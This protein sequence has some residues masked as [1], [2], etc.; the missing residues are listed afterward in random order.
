MLFLTIVI[1]NIIVI[2][3]ILS[4]YM[5]ASEWMS[6]QKDCFCVEYCIPQCNG[7]LT[8]L[9][10]YRVIIELDVISGVI[11]KI[12]LTHYLIGLPKVKTFLFYFLHK[13]GLKIQTTA[14]IFKMITLCTC[15]PNCFYMFLC[16]KQ[17][18]AISFCY[19]CFQLY[20]TFMPP[21]SSQAPFSMTLPARKC[22]CV[23]VCRWIEWDSQ[24][25][26]TVGRWV[27]RMEECVCMCDFRGG[28]GL[29]ITS[30]PGVFT[31]CQGTDTETF[32]VLFFCF[33]LFWKLWCIYS[34]TS[35]FFVCLF[36]TGSCPTLY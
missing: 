31:H 14:L 12:C 8:W 19:W 13:F 27:T 18:A 10:I 25:S 22:K 24:P 26:L 36:R 17:Q 23:H 6:K 21:G 2:N 28:G 1:D 32:F 7:L 15:S 34:V 35:H 30:P 11:F 5:Y 9:S 29:H 33:C 20:F 3:N 4:Q 16:S